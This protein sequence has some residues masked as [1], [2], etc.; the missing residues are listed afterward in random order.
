MKSPYKN[1]SLGRRREEMKK[2]PYKNVSLGRRRKELRKY[3][4]ALKKNVSLGR[5]REEMKK[6]RKNKPKSMT[7][8][9]SA[10]KKRM[11]RPKSMTERSSARKK[12]MGT[13]SLRKM[14]DMYSTSAGIRRAVYYGRIPRTPGGLTRKDL[15][16]NKYGRVVSKKKSMAAKKN[17]NL[18]C[19]LAM[20]K[21]NR[22][23]KFKPLRK[24]KK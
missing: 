9:S 8:R 10:R 14:W 11:R 3:K 5:R 16:L 22:G 2:N 13:P 7:E 18:G 12:R 20:A 17:K 24:I 1:V 21:A 19:Y 4:E 23:K 6:R 15:I